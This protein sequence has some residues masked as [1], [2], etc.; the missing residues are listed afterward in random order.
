MTDAFIFDAVRTPRGKGRAS[1]RL[2]EVPPARLAAVAL[3]ALRA[4]NGFQPAQVA[5]V[6]LRLGRRGM[7]LGAI[8]VLIIGFIWVSEA[9]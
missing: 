1:G 5:D 8:S 6:I 7:G 9:R 3:N 4:R 2:H